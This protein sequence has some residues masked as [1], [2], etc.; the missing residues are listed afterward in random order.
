MPVTS[1]PTHPG[2]VLSEEFL[3]PM[4]I[5][6][7][8]LAKEI[9][10]SE[11]HIGELVKG[12]RSV[13]ALTALRLGA[14]FCMEP[15]FWLNLQMRYDLAAERLRSA[16]KLAALRPHPQSFAALTE[17]AQQHQTEFPHGPPAFPTTETGFKNAP[18]IK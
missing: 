15:E 4:S 13:S 2:E 10:L 8:R 18:D 11:A 3:K 12:K 5:S 16:D 17:F 14:Y 9:G 1:L 7:Y 6:R